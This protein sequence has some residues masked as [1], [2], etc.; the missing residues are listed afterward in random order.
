RELDV[1][2]TDLQR[3]HRVLARSLAPAFV[4]IW[5]HDSQAAAENLLK[6]VNL[7]EGLLQSRWIPAGSPE[8]PPASLPRTP[9]G[10]VQVML[11]TEQV[12]YA[13]VEGPSGAG[14]IEIRESL[15]PREQY[16]TESVV[17]A[18]V[19]GLGI[20]DWCAASYLLLGLVLVLKPV[21]A[22]VAQARR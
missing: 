6:R 18:V 9:D 2:D 15:E 7:T 20:L 3:D 14:Y 4:V 11:A 10:M 19:G 17:R 16:V 8:A 21:R 13:P 5:E 1:F 12:T 22:L